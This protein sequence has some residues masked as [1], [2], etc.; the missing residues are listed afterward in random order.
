MRTHKLSVRIIDLS[1]SFQ[2]IKKELFGIIEIK[3]PNL[4][5]SNSV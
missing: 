2:E 5:L 3:V 4:N 1:K